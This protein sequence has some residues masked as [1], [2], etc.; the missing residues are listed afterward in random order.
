MNSC[1]F[2]ASTTGSPD[3][4]KSSSSGQVIIIAAAVGGSA[5][6]ILI[7]ILII[8]LIRRS[9]HR[10]HST[11]ARLESQIALMHDLRNRAMTV[12]SKGLTAAVMDQIQTLSGSLVDFEV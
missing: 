3:N 11:R 9:D 8:V 6:V 5:V 1:L 7:I 12:L 10:R 2:T 4:D